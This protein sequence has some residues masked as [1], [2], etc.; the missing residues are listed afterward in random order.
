[1]IRFNPSTK[2]EIKREASIMCDLV[3]LSE[4]KT[5]NIVTI[6]RYGHLKPIKGYYY[7]DMDLGAFTLA[8]YTASYFDSSRQDIEWASLQD[9]SPVVVQRNCSPTAKLENWCTIGAHIASGL[10]YMHSHRYVHRDVKPENGSQ[11][12]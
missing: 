5:L 11:S 1:V 6:L 10:K 2:A 3:N 12:H 7:I 4:S 8:N 9:S